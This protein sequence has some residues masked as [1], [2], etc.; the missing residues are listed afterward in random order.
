[1]DTPP[2]LSLRRRS[3]EDG[4][5]RA[6]TGDLLGAITAQTVAIVRRAFSIPPGCC[7]DLGHAPS[8][9]FAIVR[10]GYLTKT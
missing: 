9:A 10:Q 3:F 5:S 8:P 1:M 2:G 7:A 4:A 6:R